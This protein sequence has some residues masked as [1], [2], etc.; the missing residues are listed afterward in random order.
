MRFVEGRVRGD[1]DADIM[2][3]F[4]LARALEILGEAASKVSSQLQANL[5]GVPWREIIA[6]RNRLVHAYRSLELDTLWNAVMTDVPPLRSALRRI[7]DEDGSA[8]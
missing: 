5:P 4:A 3:A 6:M 2:L 7:L 8:S 1:L